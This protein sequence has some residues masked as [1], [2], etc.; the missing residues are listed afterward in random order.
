MSSSFEWATRPLR[1][2]VL[3]EGRCTWI[4]FET[5]SFVTRYR[6]PQSVAVWMAGKV[7]AGEVGSRELTGDDT[8][9]VD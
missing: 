8:H 7:V 4:E 6:L 5:G 3:P 9:N 1:V 2:S